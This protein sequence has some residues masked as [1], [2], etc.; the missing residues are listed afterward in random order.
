MP[1]AGKW[2][3]NYDFIGVSLGFRW[4]FSILFVLVVWPVFICAKETTN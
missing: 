1:N 3:I 2:A 4:G